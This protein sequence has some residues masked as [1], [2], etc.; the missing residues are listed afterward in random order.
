MAGKS[1]DVAQPRKRLL[2]RADSS[3]TGSANHSPISAGANTVRSSSSETKLSDHCVLTLLDAPLV[4]AS[5]D[6]PELRVQFELGNALTS[7]QAA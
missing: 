5:L 6:V 4:P 2:D 1:R 7:T 3:I